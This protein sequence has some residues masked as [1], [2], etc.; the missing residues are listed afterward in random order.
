MRALPGRL[1]RW[2][3]VPDRPLAAIEVRARSV[4]CLRL[5]RESGRLR[6]GA[7]ALVEL[8]PGVVAVSP[9]EPNVRDGE[10]FGRALRSAAE[11]AGLGA[12]AA[13]A[14]VVPDAAARAVLLTGDVEGS[15]ASLEE[16]VRFRLRKSV[17][18]EIR[19]A[20][21]AAQ[22]LPGDARGPAAVLA[23]VMARPVLESYEAPLAGAGLRPGL[24][25][26]SGLALMRFAAA[27]AGDRLLVN[28]EPDY[29]T[30]VLSRGGRPLLIRTLSAGADQ[31]LES[32][33]REISHT[34]LYHRDRL[35]GEELAGAALRPGDGDAASVAHRLAEALGRE[36]EPV[37]PWNALG[38]SLPGHRGSGLAG[39]AASLLAGERAA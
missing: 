36:P 28:L 1:G 11:Q 19:R 38:A 31:G 17:P 33:A 14:L 39:A 4:G 22:R 7:A 26:L 5:V 10:A 2:L 13:V 29:L 21:V 35:G 24:V 27:G 34:L 37:E 15:G 6:L 18:F 9:V 3:T 25:E 20:S 16:L 12:G 23:A 32:V 30:L 8:P